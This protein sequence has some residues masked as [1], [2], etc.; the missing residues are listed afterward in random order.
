MVF[1]SGSAV[2]RPPRITRLKLK[3][4]ISQHFLSVFKQ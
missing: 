3:F 2:R 4:A 1:S